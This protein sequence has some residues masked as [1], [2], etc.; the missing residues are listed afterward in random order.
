MKLF[1]TLPKSINS[2]IIIATIFI[3]QSGIITV[4]IQNNRPVKQLGKG[5]SFQTTKAFR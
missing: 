1:E 4:E 5:Y 2:I 3:I